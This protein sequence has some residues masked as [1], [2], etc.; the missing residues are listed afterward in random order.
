MSVPGSY[1][2]THVSSIRGSDGASGPVV[3]EDGVL[4]ERVTSTLLSRRE[5]ALEQTLW[6]IKRELGVDR[7][8]VNQFVD[9]RFEVLAV[10][11][12][13]MFDV[14][15]R[16]P[17]DASTHCEVAAQ[18]KVF[19]SADFRAD[20]RF[21]RPVDELVRSMGF[22]SGCALPLVA[23]DEVL[24]AISLSALR[25]NTDFTAA[26]H[27]L[28]TITGMLAMALF[29]RR[30]AASAPATMLVLHHD[31][32]IRAG[33]KHIIEREVGAVVVQGATVDEAMSFARPEDIDLSVLP[34]FLG[35]QRIDEVREDLQSAGV[36]AHIVA[37]AHN[38]T[39]LN[40]AAASY[41]RARG[42]V[43]RAAAGEPGALARTIRLVLAGK[44][45][46]L[47]SAS[48]VEPGLTARERDV[49]VALSSGLQVDQI[50]QQLTIAT[51][52]ARGYVQQVYRKLGVHSR[53][54]A[55]EEAERHGLLESLRHGE[56]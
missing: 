36:R 2:R 12:S 31:P 7:V 13:T 55:V 18:R 54:Q 20:D 30:R 43:S 50:A 40:R 44:A 49:L 28:S 9:G 10:A 21:V 41:V 45:Q 16:L 48:A 19:A 3:V 14:G 39:E 29:E 24:G 25:A 53:A 6:L 17:F 47:E 33:L 8:C 32:L 22:R 1:V 46:P 15:T 11:G 42:Y 52:T 4:A 5:D 34:T 56:A 27:A 38:D 23:G 35:G 37:L 26:T 51:S